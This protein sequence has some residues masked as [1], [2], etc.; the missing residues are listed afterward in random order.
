M[1]FEEIK[2]DYLCPVC[3]RRLYLRDMPI[4]SSYHLYRNYD[5]WPKNW[6][7]EKCD[8]YFKQIEE[9]NEVRK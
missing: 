6:Y 4:R 8:K 7:C 5:A 3:K 1:R 9:T 2:E